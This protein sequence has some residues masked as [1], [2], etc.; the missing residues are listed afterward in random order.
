MSAPNRDA[1]VFDLARIRAQLRRWQDQV[2]DITK[3]NPLIGLNRS[4]AAKLRVV[5]PDAVELFSRFV[6]DESDLRMPLV[7]KRPARTPQEPLFNEAGEPLL[8]VEPGDVEFE[9]TPLDLMRRLRRISDNARTTVEERGVTT[10]YLAFGALHWRDESF[11]DSVSPLWMVPCQLISR[12]PDAP[13]RLALADEEM[14]FN[15]ALEYCLRERH[16]IIFPELPGEISP[17][18]LHVFLDT[19]QQAVRE[20]RWEVTPEV[21]LSTFSFESLVIY[22]DL[23]AMGDVAASNRIVATLARAVE[24]SEK[25]EALP[26]DLDSLP[27]PGVTPIP[28]LPTDS[29]QLEA[30]TSAASGRHVV[31]HGPPGTGKSQTIANLI[32]TALA[33][34]K[35]VLFV[36]AKM[37]ALSVVHDRLKEL[38][39]E[40]FCLEAHSTKAG[41]AQI[42]NELRRTLEAEGSPDAN[43]LTEELEGLLRVRQQLNSYVAALHKRIDPLA[44]TVYRAIGVLTKLECAPDVRGPLPWVD[45]VSISRND[46]EDCLDLLGE[47]AGSAEVF[48]VRAAHPWRGFIHPEAGLVQQERVETALKIMLAAGREILNRM[49][50]LAEFIPQHGSLTINQVEALREALTA[51]SSLD[52]LPPNWWR[53]SIAELT[54]RTALFETAVTILTEFHEKTAHLSRSVDLGCSAVKELCSPIEGRFKGWHRCLMPGYWKWR[55]AVR[56]QL[57]PGAAN[58]L[59]ACRNYYQQA[60]RLVEIERWVAQHGE[61]LGGGAAFDQDPRDL[62]QVA[63]QLNAAALLKTALTAAN[64]QLENG[65]SQIT[66]EIRAAAIAIVSVLPSS[67]ESLAGAVATLDESWPNGFA[68]VGSVAETPLP[69]LLARVEEVAAGLARMHEWALLQRTLAKCQTRG[70]SRFIESLGS[71]SARV[72][73]AAF[74]R[75]FYMLWTSAVV[76]R[77][78]E[79]A[80]FSGT[81]RHDLIE[82]FRLLDARIRRLA[83]NKAQTV[84]SSALNRIRTAQDNVGNA[85]EVGILQYELQKKKKIKPLRKLFAEIPHVLQ[86]LKPCMLMSPISVSTYL[87]PGVLTFD[88]VVF[89]EASQLP[90]AEAVPSILRAKQVILAGDPNQLPPTSFFQAS[91]LAEDEDEDEAAKPAQEPL[92]SLLNDCVAVVPVFQESYLRWHYRSCDERLIKFSNHY[93]YDNRL[94]TFPSAVSDA[95]GQGVRLVYVP[96]GVWDRGRSRTNRA[97]ARLVARL[98]L[99][100]VEKFPDRSL[101]IVAMNAAQRE[102]IE[103]AINEELPARPDLYAFFDS[104]HPE[105]FFVKSLENV[106]GDERDTMIISIGYGKDIN[107]ASTLNFG[108]INTEGGWRR[109]NVLVTRAKWQMILVTSLRSQ[110]LSGINPSNRGAVSLRNFIEFAERNATLPTDGAVMT[111]A[112]TNDFEDAVQEALKERG[113]VVDQQVGASKYRIDLAVRDPRDPRRYLLGVECD[114]ATYHSSRTARDRDLVRQEV[115]RKM[116]WRL[117]RV[118]STEWFHHRDKAIESLLKSVEQAEAHPHEPSVYAPPPGGREAP[119]AR[120]SNTSNASARPTTPQSD[121]IGADRRYRAGDPYRRYRSVSRRSR[122]YLLQYKYTRILAEAVTSVVQ[123]EGPIHEDLL[124][125]RL[126]ELHGV[127]RAGSNIQANIRQAITWV[128]VER[129]DREFLW[130][131]G[132]LLKCFRTPADDVR[133]PIEQIPPEE[134]ELAILYLVE[135][136]F[137][138]VRDQIPQAVAKLFGVER[139]HGDSADVIRRIVDRLTDRALLRTSGPNIYLA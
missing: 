108:P 136:Q 12:G 30:L 87:K 124:I 94:I 35:K 59:A 85:S 76:Q 67:D 129:R 65:T 138:L 96:D 119:E 51:V 116:G 134:I 64:R 55:L 40:R 104:G 90:T 27:S 22:Q 121:P 79:L 82:R 6:L 98:A 132:S 105:R 18:T 41:K 24:V 60:T 74:E 112:E 58:D 47:L 46:L 118:W 23:S 38:G 26:N 127:E 131:K 113:F 36:S 45:P 11:G 48:D 63:I 17:K 37:A 4:R 52:Q 42:I 8:S 135:D 81:R 16:K 14:Q 97:E 111:P 43:A 109:L 5:Q 7:R 3:S 25:S 123:V 69:T 78:P 102:A 57:K 83:I 103:D 100:H 71:T 39:L 133:R 139:L 21:W 101:G 130:T 49:E 91:L 89:D 72:A 77:S 86:A 13:L 10:L 93:F 110:E 125:E 32:A 50:L 2:L 75:R 70:L 15:A 99:E 92:E 95:P 29:S 117:H 68:N 120:N 61:Q 128:N 115:L 122:E 56:R 53:P 44:L 66:A 114:G 34:N 31:V 106:Q 19:V 88:L 9:A 20:Q 126:K 33:G 107:G 80:E 1:P 54:E 84:A 62:E 137:G 28:V 73:R